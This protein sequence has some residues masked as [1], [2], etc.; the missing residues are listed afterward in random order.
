MA[1]CKM[2]RSI[3]KL[4]KIKTTLLEYAKA[5]VETDEKAKD[6]LSVFDVLGST[7]NA[8]EHDVET[9][10]LKRDIELSLLREETRRDLID[11]D[12]DD[13][14]AVDRYRI[15]ADR[16]ERVATVVQRA[17]TT[18]RRIN[19]EVLAA[20]PFR[21]TRICTSVAAFAKECDSQ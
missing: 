15:A 1:T 5:H 20:C 17:T 16:G 4:K 2:R 12:A 21:K 14:R 13:A 18:T 11:R 7:L 8:L 10:R 6:V 19:A 3:R 9:E